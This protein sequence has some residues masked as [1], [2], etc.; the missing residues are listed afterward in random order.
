MQ[1]AV[2]LFGSSR[3]ERDNA[4]LREQVTEI[5]DLRE[6]NTKLNRI[7]AEQAKQL[8]AI[9]KRLESE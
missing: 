3:L 6:D 1:D 9:T 4:V 7:V 8:E 2:T 5:E